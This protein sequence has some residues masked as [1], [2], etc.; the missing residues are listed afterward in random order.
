MGYNFTEQNYINV[1][2][3]RYNAEKRIHCVWMTS[4]VTF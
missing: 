2:I 4:T 3:L 1:R